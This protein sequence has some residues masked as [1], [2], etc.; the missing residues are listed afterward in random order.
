MGKVVGKRVSNL[1]RL[2]KLY[3]E[4]V[5]LPQSNEVI[6]VMAGGSLEEKGSA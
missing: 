4:V 6:R 1:E 5:V 3:H 2:C